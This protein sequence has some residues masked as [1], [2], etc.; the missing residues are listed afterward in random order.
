MGL[1]MRLLFVLTCCVIV[2]ACGGD[3]N[4]RVCF[5]S[6]EFCED[7]FGRNRSPEADAGR[8]QEV[9][10]GELVELDGTD[11]FDPDGRIASLSWTQ[12]SG[13]TV[14]LEDASEEIAAFTAPDVEVETV[15]EF[16][17][18]VTDDDD[19][20]DDDRVL[21]TVIPAAAAALT[22]GVELLTTV[23][24]PPAAATEDNCGPCW[25]FLGLWLGARV[26]AALEGAEPDVDEL[27]DALRMIAQ[28]NI[29]HAPDSTLP[30][31]QRRLFELGQRQVAAFTAERDPA[32]AE[33]AEFH[34][35][36]LDATDSILQWR[37]DLLAAYPALIWFDGSA[38]GRERAERLLLNA[39]P[40]T[41]APEAV[42]AATLLLALPE[43][44]R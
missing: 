35:A 14:T 8:D 2:G 27:L 12:R 18:V 30:L 42:A 41:V 7:A 17:L 28:L 26:Q 36:D 31:A 43:G 6:S 15:L 5:G 13:D 9:V 20:S 4:T 23:H 32:V 16:R 40:H 3:D 24:V 1:T 10:A 44:P 19:A 38:A 11:S 37:R 21:V 22:V 34:A 29:A 33:L 25:S 39:D